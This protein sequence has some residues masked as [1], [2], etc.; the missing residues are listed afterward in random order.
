LK[1]NPSRITVIE[2]P[3]E[4]AILERI[5][6]FVVKVRV[7]GR[8]QRAYINNTGRLLRYLVRGRKGFCIRPAKPGKTDCRLFSIKEDEFAAII[9]TQLQMRVFERALEMD[10]M[11]W[12]RKSRILRRNANLGES[13][14]DYLLECSGERVY[15]E[16]KSAV[17]R[18]GEY[19]MYPDCPSARG[20]RHVEE[21]TDHVEKGGQGTILFIAAMPGVKAF[22]PNRSADPELHGLVKKA[23]NAGVSLKSIGLYY[24]PEDS[25]VYLFEPDLEVNIS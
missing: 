10:L 7:D 16:V 1:R 9:D 13:S 25:S 19:A 18:E 12:M 4:C 2:E 21:L 17:L 8:P 23:H 3:I 5:N 15:L 20:R 14:I 24:S 11:P 6:K 22:R